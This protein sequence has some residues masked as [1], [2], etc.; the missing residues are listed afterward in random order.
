MV[1]ALVISL[2]F[3]MM[4][5]ST[6]ADRSVRAKLERSVPHVPL[7]VERILQLFNRYS[8]H[9]TWNVVGA[10]ACSG[11]QE[12]RR[13]CLEA[14]PE[15]YLSSALSFVDQISDEARYFAPGT[16]ALIIGTHGQRIA[17]HSFTHY[18]VYEHSENVAATLGGEIRLSKQALA[19][20]GAGIRAIAFPK[21]QINDAALAACSS[22]G[23]RIYR[24]CRQSLH[25]LGQGPGP[26]NRV[27]RL[28]DAY[29]VPVLGSR[30]YCWES[31]RRGD[32][33]DVRES[34]FFR[35]YSRLLASLE[36]LKLSV[37]KREMT[38]AAR[39]G[40]VYHLWWHPHEFAP[41][42]ERNLQQLESILQHYQYLK[43]TYAFRS[44]S[45]EECG[46]AMLN[47]YA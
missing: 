47:P 34:R 18:A 11:K 24:G 39:H 16:V 14:I 4:W 36:P 30:S 22:Q 33:C 29:L 3:E 21:N 5:G 28:L 43:A 44:L 20:L 15:P 35:P 41:A 23:I 26:L 38:M 2:D 27:V 40:E 7:I 8:I 9:A 19:R 10:L 46:L 32:M 12:A 17:S 37:I 1:G 31:I 25:R 6:N 45:M 13:L 42:V